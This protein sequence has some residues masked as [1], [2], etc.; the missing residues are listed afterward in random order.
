M[1]ITNGYCTQAELKAWQIANGTWTSAEDDLLDAAINTASR[2][3]DKVCGRR[4]YLDA[5]ATAKVYR[6]DSPTFAWVDDIGSTSGLV[7]KTD[8]SGDGTFATTWLSTDYELEPANTEGSWA[9]WRIRAV[10]N[11]SFVT[12]ARRSSLQVTAKWGWSSVPDEIATACKALAARLD[13]A[14]RNPAGVA[15]FGEFGAIRIARTDPVV[16]S[17]LEPFHKLSAQAVG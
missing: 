14:R 8:T 10:D 17:L 4:F 7:I 9:V 11:K 2:A 16:A 15:S 12:M 6:P 3:I 5:S 1:T 13:F